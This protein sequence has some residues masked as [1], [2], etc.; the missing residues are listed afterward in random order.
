MTR[1]SY[2]RKATTGNVRFARAARTRLVTVVRDKKEV[3]LSVTLETGR[4]LQA[5]A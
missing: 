1:N 5:G 2:Q 3:T 4:G